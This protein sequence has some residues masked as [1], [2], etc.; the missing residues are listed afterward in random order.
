[1]LLHIKKQEELRQLIDT[2]RAFEGRYY[3]EHLYNTLIHS[4]KSS[5][6]IEATVDQLIALIKNIND[7][8]NPTTSSRDKVKAAQKIADNYQALVNQ[9]G[10]GGIFY[11][12]KQALLDLGGLIIGIIT[13]VFGSI[14][15]SIAL[16]IDDLLNWRLPT[17]PFIGG[18]TGLLVGYTL[19]QRVPHKLFKDSENRSIR[20]AVSK[21]KATFDSLFIAQENNYMEDISQEILNDYFQGNEEEF[22]AFLKGKHK[23][24]IL[25][26]KAQFFSDSLKGTLGH[27]S[28]IRFNITDSGKPK[29]IEMGVPSDQEVDFTQREI[30]ETTGEQLINMLVMDKILRPQ[31]ELSLKNIFNFAK[32]YQPGVRDCHTYID[33][34]LLSAGEPVSHIQ[35]FTPEDTF[36]GRFIGGAM[37]FFSPLP[38]LPEKS[39]SPA[40]ICDCN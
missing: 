13:G 40:P 27:H 22:K 4:N 36:I 31:Y 33:K 32:R 37:R 28:F 30:R 6:T 8:T 23:Y 16:G 3:L 17:G 11:K 38:P 19:G 5:E 1:M 18:F 9:T 39:D 26:I 25:G 10:A 12:C 35:R 24:E 2:C 34:V 15:G 20:H 21:L 14:F 7:I 29:L